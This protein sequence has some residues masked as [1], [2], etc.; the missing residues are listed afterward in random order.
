MAKKSRKRRSTGFRW[1]AFIVLLLFGIV[2]YNRTAL[3][4]ERKEKEAELYELQLV[5]AR[6]QERSLE[7]VDE[8]A[9]RQTKKYIEELA[10]EKIG[11]VY[12]DEII[13]EENND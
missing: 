7:L 6:E 1:I 11:L 4:Y 5:Y 13:F 8:K 3:E 2:S 10:R 12:E 9:Y